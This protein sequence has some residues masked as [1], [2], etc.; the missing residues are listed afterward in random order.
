MISKTHDIKIADFGLA[1]SFQTD[2][3]SA[4][5]NRVITLWYRPPELLLGATKYGP[6]IDLWSVGCI[7]AELLTGKPLLP[8]KNEAEQMDLIFRMCGTPTEETWPGVSKLQWYTTFCRPGERPH[9]RRLAEHLA[10]VSP[11]ARDLCEKL[12]TMDPAKRMSARDALLHDYFSEATLPKRAR[13]EELGTYEESHEYTTKKRRQEARA[14]QEGAAAGAKAGG[15]QPHPGPLQPGIRGVS[16]AAPVEA[17]LA[18]ASG[19]GSVGAGVGGTYGPGGHVPPYAP[20]YAPG[21]AH[22]ARPPPAQPL[23]PPGGYYPQPYGAP[24]PGRPLLP[25]PPHAPHGGY[26]AAPPRPSEA[27]AAAAREAAARAQQRPLP[28]GGRS[29]R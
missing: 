25:P 19:V 3:S 26:H 9:R 10:K 1:R 15:A 16:R 12:L 24:P 22:P 21:Y 17:A 6:E 2:S 5:T 20:G 11:D 14:A 7:L 27:A 8:G 29:G 23:P 18:A 4:L 28:P 13:P